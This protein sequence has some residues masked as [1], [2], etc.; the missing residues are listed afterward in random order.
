MPKSTKIC[1][2]CEKRKK[3]DLF[4]QSGK[5]KRANGSIYQNY[6]SKCKKCWST[7]QSQ[8]WRDN[9]SRTARQEKGVM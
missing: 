7:L 2:G 9:Y 5:V 8:Y 4:A 6:R 3:I 1:T